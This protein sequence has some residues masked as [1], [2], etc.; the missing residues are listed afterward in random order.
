MTSAVNIKTRSPF[1]GM[2]AKQE[3]R[4]IKNKNLLEVKTIWHC[5]ISSGNATMFK[6]LDIT[7]TRRGF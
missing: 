5:F 6:P 1:V 3:N 4:F 7:G 2:T